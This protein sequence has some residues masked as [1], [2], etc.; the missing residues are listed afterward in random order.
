M[1]PRRPE[2]LGL[3]IGDTFRPAHGVVDDN[4]GIKHDAFTVVGILAPTGSPTDRPLFLNMEGFY[5]L[6]NHA[7][8]VPGAPEPPKAEHHDDHDHDHFTPCPRIGAAS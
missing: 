5:A 7:K 3:K 8:P 6:E 4:Q 1:R 2:E